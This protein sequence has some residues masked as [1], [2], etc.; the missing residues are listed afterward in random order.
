MKV[1][2]CRPITAVRH[3]GAG[4]GKPP[5]K[6][7]AR[8]GRRSEPCRPTITVME[9]VDQLRCEHEGSVRRPQWPSELRHM[10]KSRARDSVAGCGVAVRSGQDL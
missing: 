10:K 9:R 3:I 6:E 1:F 5:G 4:V 2:R 8:G 7:P